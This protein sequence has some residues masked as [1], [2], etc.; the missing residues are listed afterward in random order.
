MPAVFVFSNVKVSE[1]EGTNQEI[2]KEEANCSNGKILVTVIGQLGQRGGRE[3]WWFGQGSPVQL[4]MTS[5]PRVIILSLGVSLVVAHLT[6][7]PSLGQG[8]CELAEDI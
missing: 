5:Q 3:P 2:Q 6:R 8:A 4:E 7:L 1:P